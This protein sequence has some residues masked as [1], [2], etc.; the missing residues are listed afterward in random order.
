VSFL[1]ER[2]DLSQV[3]VGIGNAGLL[4]EALLREISNVI[5]DTI[6]VS[7]I[8][9]LRQVVHGDNTKLTDLR[10][11]VNLGIAQ[12]ILPFS[13]GIPRS[14]SVCQDCLDPFFTRRL[15]PFFVRTVSGFAIQFVGTFLFT[16]IVLVQDPLVRIGRRATTDFPP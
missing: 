3:V 14:E 4:D 8:G 12:G 10:K 9:K 2:D 1:G 15:G 11:Q 13:V 7:I 5:L 16:A 6:S